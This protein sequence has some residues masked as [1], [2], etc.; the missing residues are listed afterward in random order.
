MNNGQVSLRELAEEELLLALPLVPAC[1][2][3]STCG[4]APGDTSGAAP[5][6]ATGQMRR[7]FS[8]LQDILKKL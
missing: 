2:S 4:K 5:A 1:R 3:P 6:G 8:A 7:P